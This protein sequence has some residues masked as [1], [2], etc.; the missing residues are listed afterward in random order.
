M[1]EFSTDTMARPLDALFREGALGNLSD[2][3]LLERLPA[4]GAAF[5][6]LMARHGT[7]VL[8][9]CRRILR[10]GHAADDAFQVT[11]LVLARRARAIRRRES[12]G[13]WLHGVARRVA[14]RARAAAAMRQEREARAAIDPAAAVTEAG[15]DELGPALH[16]EIDRLPEKYRSPIVLCYLQGRTIDEA[17]RQL[18]W[19]V[20]TVGGRLARARDRL[21]DRLV[22]QGLVAPTLLIA[23]P[24]PNTASVAAV[25]RALAVSTCAAALQLA[26]GRPATAVVSAIVA[27]LLE[28]TVRSIAWTRFM[29]GAG[30]CG[31][32]G[33]LASG[34]A[35]ISLMAGAVN[36]PT[37]P[38]PQALTRAA[39]DPLRPA[40]NPVAETLNQA[41][42]A[43]ADLNDPQEKLD[44]HMAL[45][46][47]Q[48]KTGDPA[49]VR[50]SLDHATEAASALEMEPRCYS[51]VRIAQARG[52]TGDKQRGL[53][54][55]AQTAHRRRTAREKADLAAEG[56][57]HGP[58]RAR[59]SGRR[60]CDYQSPR[61][62]DP[63]RGEPAEGALEYQPVRRRRST[64]CHRRR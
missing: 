48:I 47:A 17:S 29:I 22:Q 37:P 56:H 61:P 27:N 41:S 44:A 63:Q 46:W 45:A 18:G 52:E 21:R 31:L 16:A 24:P 51:R 25:P 1:A 14:L 9:V 54:L 8:A 10:D 39:S 23:S 30:F 28:Q 34:A 43:A 26:A 19:P 57:R 32:L 53:D 62:G 59:R 49:G 13:P 12:L 2:A 55:L 35:G 58:R 5:D 20:G 7:M 6:V 38:Q 4:S 3:E 33:T 11:F 60:A 15:D 64:A 50:A 42:R 40:A 36:D